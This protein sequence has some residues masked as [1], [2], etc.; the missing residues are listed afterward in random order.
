LTPIRWWQQNSDSLKGLWSKTCGRRTLAP[1]I[2]VPG[3]MVAG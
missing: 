3:K 1:S 2:P